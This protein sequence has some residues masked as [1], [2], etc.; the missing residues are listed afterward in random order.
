MKNASPILDPFLGT[1][2]SRFFGASRGFAP[3][4]QGAKITRCNGG[5][6]GG[7]IIQAASPAV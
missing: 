1:V 6:G 2:R 3:A 5:K 7:D 4:D